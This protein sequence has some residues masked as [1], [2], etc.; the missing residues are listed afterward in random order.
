MTKTMITSSDKVA[1]RD[2][3]NPRIA[4]DPRAEKMFGKFAAIKLHR[5][6]GFDYKK[7]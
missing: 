2:R 4:R 5:G 7:G 6:C 3:E 1:S